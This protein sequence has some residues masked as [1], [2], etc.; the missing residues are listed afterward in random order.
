VSNDEVRAAAEILRHNAVTDPV[1]R[2]ATLEKPIQVVTPEGELDSWFVPLTTDEG[3]IGFLQLEPDLTLHR[4]SA[5]EHSQPA[6]A[7]LDPDRIR[8]HAQAA[9]AEGEELGD[10]VLTYRGNRDRLTWRV[11]I[12]NRPSAIF[13]AGD[14]VEVTPAS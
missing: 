14:Y 3:L 13:V 10:P 8:A 7:W 6:S 9:A 2:S 11:P 12:R 4:Y 5:F 1:A